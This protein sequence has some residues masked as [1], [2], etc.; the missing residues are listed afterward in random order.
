MR[1]AGN[2]LVLLGDARRGVHHDEADIGTLH[3]HVGTQDGILL[4][5]VVD[6]GRAADPR[7]VDEAEFPVLVLDDGIDGVT[8]RA[9]NV[10]DDQTVGAENAVDH[11]GFPGVRFTDDGD[12]DD[13]VVL[14]GR[15]HLR[16]IG[17]H[18]VEQVARAGAVQ[19]GERD[20]ILF[21]SEF[22][23]LIIFKRQVAGAVNLVDAGDDG[24]AALREHNGNLAIVGGQPRA[25]VA[26]E[27]DNVRRI[28]GNLRLRAHLFQNDVVGLGF[29]AAGVDEGKRVPAPFGLAVDA[30]ARD[31][32]GVLDD[33]QALTDDLIEE[34]RFPD[35]R[36]ADN[37][38]KGF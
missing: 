26:D 5:L 24:F 19:G 11:R 29:D 31:T 15:R 10:R 27:N 21:Q 18:A 38:N 17:D 9:R 7:R 16:E 35:V 1:D 22:V 3:R 32:G 23:K 12:A 36:S 20:G 25:H 28:N 6:L 2:M 34:R 14:L 13:V 8:R 4:D 37:G 30:V 33:R